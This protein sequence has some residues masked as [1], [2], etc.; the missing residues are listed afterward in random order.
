MMGLVGTDMMDAPGAPDQTT[1]LLLGLALAFIIGENAALFA[2]L[3]WPAAV[4]GVGVALALIALALT[5]RMP[6][7]ANLKLP[8]L[9]VFMFLLGML[10]YAASLG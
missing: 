2:H 7:L 4:A 6:G 3:N 1:K 5:W 8:I 10:A 9:F